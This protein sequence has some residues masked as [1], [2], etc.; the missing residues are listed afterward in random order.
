[1]RLGALPRRVRATPSAI[2]REDD[3]LRVL[4]GELGNR[5]RGG[6]R[7]AAARGVRGA[8]RGGDGGGDRLRRGGDGGC[9]GAPCRR[10]SDR[11]EARA[12]G[13]AVHE[14]SE[15]LDRGNDDR[16]ELVPQVVRRGDG[17]RELRGVARRR[18]GGGGESVCFP[19]V[20][21]QRWLGR[22]LGIPT[23]PPP[24]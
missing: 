15:E 24:C 19:R 8:A 20:R 17:G 16:D 14:D 13:V 6:A 10:Y 18:K 2:M 7:L 11:G 1:M 3:G 4:G 5:V 23:T 9:D 22:L 21:C 12:S